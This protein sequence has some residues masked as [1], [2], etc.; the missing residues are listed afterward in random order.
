MILKNFI[1][2]REERNFFVWVD[3]NNFLVK[4][5]IESVGCFVS[6]CF[7][8]NTEQLMFIP[9]PSFKGAVSPFQNNI[10]KVLRAEYNLEISRNYYFAGYPSRLEA[11]FLLPDEEEAHKYKKRYIEH[12]NNRILKKVKTVGEYICSFH[13]SSWIDFLRLGHGM[14][15]ES[16]HQATNMY[17]NGGCVRDNQL[18][19]C[20]KEWT[21]D[22]IIE[23]LFLGRVDFYDKHL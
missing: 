8:N 1:K 11:I 4:H 19:S 6:N 14:D 2:G 10:T 18:S 16:I 5:N 3:P 9:N 13:D 22:P 12:V 20:G 17:W 7:P 21:E 23:I 15:E